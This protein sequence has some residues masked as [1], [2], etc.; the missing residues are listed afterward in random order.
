MTRDHAIRRNLSSPRVSLC[1][2]SKQ[3]KSAAKLN[4]PVC[5]C[6][7]A[8]LPMRETDC[9]WRLFYC[10]AMR[11]L[12]L[13]PLL[14]A[15]PKACPARR[16]SSARSLVWARSPPA[17]AAPSASNTRSS[18]PTIRRSGPAPRTALVSV[19]VPCL[20]RNNKT[21]ELHLEIIYLST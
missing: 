4:A 16:W 11:P 10:L 15:G 9:R 14:T 5:R 6:F 3:S 1:R 7:N 8:A 18:T 17:G 2:L 20:R 12:R 13:F 21:L 19:L